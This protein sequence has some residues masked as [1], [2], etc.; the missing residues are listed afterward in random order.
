MLNFAYFLF[1][2]FL[3]FLISRKCENSSRYKI[4]RNFSPI[5]RNLIK[6]H[7][8]TYNAITVDTIF[9]GEQISF[10]VKFHHRRKVSSHCVTMSEVENFK[11]IL[12]V[13]YF[14]KLLI[15]KP[16]TN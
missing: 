16:L 2:V 9:K 12:T 7:L 13:N 15:Q 5:L 6:I 4:F 1:Y 11:K 14:G 10:S 8:I 3:R